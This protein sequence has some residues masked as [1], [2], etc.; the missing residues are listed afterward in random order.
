MAISTSNA[1]GLALA[2]DDASKV[3]AQTL[4]IAQNEAWKK[5]PRCSAYLCKEI[6]CNTMAR[7]WRC[8]WSEEDQKASLTACQQ[9]LEEVALP[10][11]RDIAGVQS[12]QR[13]V[14]GENKDFKV[15]V[16]LALDAFEEWSGVSFH[17][18]QQVLEQL[19]NIT[20]VTK[21]ECQTYTLEPVFG[22]GK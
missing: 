22:K 13:I 11:L 15:I 6:H 10:G 4:A 2:K 5:H 19:S 14:C 21:I 8:K 16:K 7:E 20:G 9:T 1:N 17:P 18:E 12:V 3:S